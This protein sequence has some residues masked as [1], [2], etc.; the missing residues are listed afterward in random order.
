MSNSPFKVTCDEC[1]LTLHYTEGRFG[2]AT[3]LTPEAARNLAQALL[4][5]AELCEDAQELEPQMMG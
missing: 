4:D 2:F 1:A 3:D 5:Q